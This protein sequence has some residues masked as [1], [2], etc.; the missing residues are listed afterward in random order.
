MNSHLFKNRHEAGL[1]LA[2]LLKTYQ[3]KPETMVLALPRG[4]V[5]VAFPIA[6]NLHLALDVFIVR[7]IGMPGHEEFAI[8]ALADQEVCILSEDIINRYQVDLSQVKA[9]IERE[10][11]ELKRRQQLYRQ[12]HETINLKFKH[13]ILV[14]DGIATG[15]TMKAA[16]TALRSLQVAEIILATPV[17]AAESLHEL[18]PLVDKIV[19]PYTPEP[20]YAVGQWY[21]TFDQTSDEEV[22]HL[23]AEAAAS[24]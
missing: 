4:G 23:L 9:I 15:A 2:H 11:E 12:D 3:G 8:G 20:F 22:L 19:C 1:Y 7:K 17:A 14:D 21:E 6:K 13:I 18:A 10:K 24:Q 16:I 5:P